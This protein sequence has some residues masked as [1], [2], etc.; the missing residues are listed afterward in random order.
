MHPFSKSHSADSSDGLRHALLLVHYFLPVFAC[1]SLALV[2][3]RATGWTL[4]P[5]GLALLLAGTGAAYSFDRIIDPAPACVPR[6]IWLQRTL[7]SIFAVCVGA[8]VILLATGEIRTGVIGV[9]GVL[10]AVSLLYPHLKRIPLI[11]TLA[12]ALAWTWACATL[13]F[14]VNVARASAWTWL[15][16][17]ATLPLLLLLSAACTLCDLKD[18]D[19][20]RCDQIPSLPVLIGTRWTCVVATVLALA[21]AGSAAM[22]HHSGLVIASFLLALAAQVPT[23]LARTPIGPIV[24]DSILIV[25]GVLI[26]TRLV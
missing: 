3:R 11:K 7:Y 20:D 10:A 25:P 2:I 24:I 1:C 15:R 5:S 16:T 12:V 21:S 9:C 26:L 6:P 17:D 22:H 23:L 14:V 19:R 8:M 18:A 4:L 13:P